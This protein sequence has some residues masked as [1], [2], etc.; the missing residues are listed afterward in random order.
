MLHTLNKIFY[1]V[2]QIDLIAID[3][4][5]YIRS[6]SDALKEEK[7]IE[8]HTWQPETVKMWSDIF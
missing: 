5:N 1:Q 2:H 6:N 7:I 3:E 8:M 4:K